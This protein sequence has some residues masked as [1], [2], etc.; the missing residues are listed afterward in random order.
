MLS[1]HGGYSSQL[2]LRIP[3]NVK[4]IFYTKKGNVCSI[5]NNEVQTRICEN[6]NKKSYTYGG[7]RYVD[8][9]DNISNEWMNDYYFSSD[10]VYFTLQGQTT[11]DILKNMQLTFLNFLGFNPQYRK[12][13]SLNTKW[14]AGVRL[15]KVY[16]QSFYKTKEKEKLHNI[17]GL[18]GLKKKQFLKVNPFLPLM[19]R[20]GYI[21]KGVKL[22]V[23]DKNLFYSGLVKC[24]N[25]RVI[26]NLDTMGPIWLSTLLARIWKPNKQFIIHAVVCRTKMN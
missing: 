8:V 16:T 11:R 21:P 19:Y 24:S 13:I 4:I 7:G 6:P 17:L 22:N 3:K 20:T 18:L 15:N 25:N 1:A 10:L 23:P 9:H 2:K 14:K 26:Y 12:K 5:W